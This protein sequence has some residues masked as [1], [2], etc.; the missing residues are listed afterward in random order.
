MDI[1]IQPIT[2]PTKGTGNLFTIDLINYSIMGSS[3]T[4][5]W[6]VGYIN[7]NFFHIVLEGNLVMDSPD[8]DS[9]G[10]DDTYVIDWALNKLNF[11]RA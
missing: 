8:I 10:T 9:W 11:T 1:E 5:Y 2:I 6:N 3:A 4:F 7:D